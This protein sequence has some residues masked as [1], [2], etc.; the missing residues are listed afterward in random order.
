[1]TGF[2]REQPYNLTDDTHGHWY[3]AQLGGEVES[4]CIPVGW[5]AT[6]QRGVAI[7]YWGATPTCE[8]KRCF[9][10]ELQVYRMSCIEAL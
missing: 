10:D 8:H 2:C 6:L 3:L 4:T 7:Q 9:D 5:N 1:M